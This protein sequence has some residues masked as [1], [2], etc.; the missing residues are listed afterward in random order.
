MK[1]PKEVNAFGFWESM[2]ESLRALT[3]T[4]SYST[5]MDFGYGGTR[6][7]THINYN[8]EEDDGQMIYRLNKHCTITV[9]KD[10]P[11]NCTELFDI[12]NSVKD[13]IRNFHF[14]NTMEFEPFDVFYRDLLNPLP[15]VVGKINLVDA[16]ENS[17]LCNADEGEDLPY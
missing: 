7:V 6:T 5:E 9:P 4:K 14:L 3:K 12:A 11:L 17:F 13:E 2:H 15:R 1:T 8:V 16:E 10:M